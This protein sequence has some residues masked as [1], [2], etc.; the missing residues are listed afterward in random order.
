[1]DYKAAEVLLKAVEDNCYNTDNNFAYKMDL[2]HKNPTNTNFKRVYGDSKGKN[3]VPTYDTWCLYCDNKSATNRCTGCKH[4][5]FCNADCQ[6]KAWPI[7]KKHCKRDLFNNCASCGKQ[8]NKAFVCDKCPVNWCSQ[9][10]KD[11]IFQSHE[12]IDCNNFQ[13]LFPK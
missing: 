13:R 7:H 1:M 2:Y 12:D 8:S 5:Y 3:F 6:K 10:C 9:E 11:K 4:I